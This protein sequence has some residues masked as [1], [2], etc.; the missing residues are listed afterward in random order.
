M[1]ELTLR[2]PE[3]KMAFF[4]ELLN[5]LG[6]EISD[7]SPVHPPET[8]RNNDNPSNHQIRGVIV[9]NRPHDLP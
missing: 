1:K 5:E 7:N 4:L 8:S 6:I 2:I 3:H 9:S